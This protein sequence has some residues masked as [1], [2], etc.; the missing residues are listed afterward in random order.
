MQFDS[1]EQK[2][3]AQVYI[4]PCFVFDLDYAYWQSSYNPSPDW[5]LY[6]PLDK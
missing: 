2:S 1:L 4:F 6:H 3:L 5:L